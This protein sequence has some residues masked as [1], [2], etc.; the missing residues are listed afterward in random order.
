MPISVYINNNCNDYQ[1]NF[2]ICLFKSAY[3]EGS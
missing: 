3:T 1:I 2:G